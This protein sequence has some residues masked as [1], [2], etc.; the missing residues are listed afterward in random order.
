[1][2]RF[3][4]R[5]PIDHANDSITSSPNPAQPV[6]YRLHASQDAVF[7]AGVPI[8]A[9]D[10][11][12][13]GR[14]AV[15]GGRHILKIVRF[16][17]CKVE[18]HA[19]LRASLTG[20]AARANPSA[21]ASVGD[22][23][24]IK[25]VKWASSSG[26]A[27]SLY[28]ACG[29]GK[30]FHYDITRSFGAIG[31][32]GAALD[33]IT[34]R[35]DTRQVNAL[36][37]NPHRDSWLLSGSQ[38]GFVRC[39]DTRD[40]ISINRGGL[41]FRQIHAGKCNDGVRHVK[42]SPKEGFCFACGTDSGVVMKW[43]SRM[44]AKPVLRLNAHE[45]NR[46]CTTVAWH[47]DGEHLASAGTDSK[48]HVW[49]A[50]PGADKKQKPKLSITLPAPAA[51]MTWR[52]G[53]WSATVQ[54][55]RAAQIAVSY[56][57]SS[58]GKRHSNAVVH[59]WD[60]ARPTMPYREVDRF[61]VSPMSLLWLDSDLLWTAGPDGI[62]SQC[63]VAF[64]P[65]VIDR[66]PVS[67]MAFSP[68][69]DV[70]MLLDER[71]QPRRPRLPAS[72]HRMDM[73]PPPADSPKEL[74][75][76]SP[77]ANMFSMGRSDS[78]DE[79]V[80]SFLGPRKPEAPAVRSRRASI[81]SSPN[82]VST[83]PPSTTIS[84]EP[85]VALEPSL[86]VAGI[87]KNHQSMAIGHVPAAPRVDIYHFLSS[88]YL[89]TLANEL[90]F[91]PESG[92][93][94]MVD[95][96]VGILRHYARAADAVSQ[97]RLAQTWRILAFAMDLL[98]RSRAQYH[99]GR[100]MNQ[101]KLRL[102][103]SREERANAK[104]GAQP[105]AKNPVTTNELT[106]R[107][108]FPVGTPRPLARSLL[109]EEFESTSNVPTPLAR[110][111]SDV[112]AHQRNQ[113]HESPTSLQ[114]VGDRLMSTS[115]VENL[116]LP[117][118]VHYRSDSDS[119]IQ[120]RKRLDSIPL[121]EVSHGSDHTQR[122][123][124]EGYDFY[125]MDAM[126]KA[127]DVPHGSRKSLGST[128]L[129][130]DYVEPKSPESQKHR[131]V[132]RKDSTESIGNVF[133]FSQTSAGSLPSTRQS[134]SPELKAGA[135]QRGR[136]PAPTSAP[137]QHQGSQS[138]VSGELHSRI[139]GRD[140]SG[141]PKYPSLKL[142]HQQRTMRPTG[143]INTQTSDEYNADLV[144]D[145]QTT[146]DTQS[147]QRTASDG[148]PPSF[149]ASVDPPLPIP[150][151]RTPSE[152][153]ESSSIIEGDYLPWQDDPPYPFPTLQAGQESDPPLD[154]FRATPLQPYALLARALDF[155]KKHSA[156]NASAMILLLRPLVPDGLIDAHLANSI[157]RQHHSRLMGMNL[158][159]EAALLRKLCV[160]GWP[161]GVLENYWVEGYPAVFAQ[162]QQGVSVAYV[163]GKCKRPREMDRSSTSSDTVWK[164]CKKCQTPAGPCAICGHR[165]VT[166]IVDEYDIPVP[167]GN[168][169]GGEKAQEQ[170]NAG[171][172]TKPSKMSPIS[173]WWYCPT[174]AHGGH[175]SCMSIWHGV[176]LNSR[177]ADG[178]TGLVGGGAELGDA[179]PYLAPEMIPGAGIS[180]GCCPVDGCGHACLPG[181][182][183]A[184][185]TAARTDEVSRASLREAVAAATRASYSAGPSARGSPVLPPGGGQQPQHLAG[186]SDL[187]LA[188]V[189]GDPH[190]AP[191]SRA[192]D[193]VRDALGGHLD[194]AFAAGVAARRGGSIS[195]SSSPGRAGGMLGGGL[196]PSASGN[197]PFGHERER[198]KSVKFA[199]ADERR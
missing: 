27:Q 75:G 156:L 122:S 112:T 172:A 101:A 148:P 77:V 168:G 181:R 142:L 154:N 179:F 45:A 95:R 89:E 34:I 110:P 102:E 139:R 99:L 42:W 53:Q 78:E 114:H 51:A 176:S 133:Y 8:A 93:K 184:E 91:N 105:P 29:N 49:D 199:G 134:V 24:S 25:D 191:Q 11:S 163:C 125:D 73:R 17:G 161:G 81:K 63:D 58:A 72:L 62:F 33:T 166:A 4:G 151:L 111:V 50:S 94:P 160:R 47:H 71:T 164:P 188:L 113:I 20:Q 146:L 23:L 55:R 190:E 28:T 37:V 192:V 66:T 115:D 136:R 135:V 18:E 67:A 10:R 116:S 178:T 165:H 92:S 30:I 158:F 86:K 152:D 118:A 100:R 46:A 197:L 54:G 12:P 40:P 145:S 103:S 83:T 22:K 64:A 167:D 43:D 159:V 2:R 26:G 162:A 36:D 76:S 106:P 88:Q 173:T 147:S 56:D 127:M 65:K 140:L 52:P 183:R 44:S 7:Q 187:S 180:D 5:P 85:A 170:D 131:P 141:S 108:Q 186:L 60:F 117:P 69:G 70:V 38:D 150:N 189:R 149:P 138:P 3:L 90:P 16:D 193:G 174:C 144:L 130:S 19:D 39:F 61:D 119:P 80:T 79:V 126:A 171:S 13:D 1:M 98:L 41:T 196:G 87:Y 84:N 57:T 123:I 128:P 143:A 182:Y 195:L 104:G 185:S 31:R 120:S 14:S 175:S 121:S 32:P 96:V 109:A 194:R 48:L 21:T 169:G 68:R 132:L 6:V 137:S 97:F 82:T 74:V 15:L 157:L 129:P 155:E 177:Q 107:Q 198:R 124:T 59:L 153:E 9:L 35:E